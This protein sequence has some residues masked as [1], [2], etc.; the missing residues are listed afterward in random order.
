[1]PTIRDLHRT[2]TRKTKGTIAA[3]QL[4]VS[5]A[6]VATK[7]KKTQVI[8]MHPINWHQDH[9]PIQYGIGYRMHVASASTVAATTLTIKT[10]MVQ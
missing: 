5:T 6:A 4:S 1:M 2:R 10:Q 7:K 8:I 3:T 9:L